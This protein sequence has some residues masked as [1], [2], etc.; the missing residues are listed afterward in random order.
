MITD[1]DVI[2]LYRCLL[3]RD[4]ESAGTV[5]AFRAYYPEFDLGRLAVLGSDEFSRVLNR[6][7]GRVAAELTRRFLQSRKARPG[8]RTPCA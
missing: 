8:L 2:E 4:P 3:G 5:P 7:T 1:Q 6:Q